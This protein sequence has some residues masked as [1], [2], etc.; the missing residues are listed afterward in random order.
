MGWKSAIGGI[1]PGVLQGVQAARGIQDIWNDQEERPIRQ[2]MLRTQEKATALDYGRKE[3]EER[4][5]NQPVNIMEHP[6]V[7]TM[8]KHATEDERKQITTRLSNVPQTQRGV[9]YLKNIFPLDEELVGIASKTG[10][11]KLNSDI[12]TKS[13][14]L[15]Q[16]QNVYMSLPPADPR[17]MELKTQLDTGYAEL[18]KIESILDEYTSNPTKPLNEVKINRIVIQYP[19]LFKDPKYKRALVYARETSDPEILKKIIT[20]RES[21]PNEWEVRV[22]AAGGDPLKA[23]QEKDRARKELKQTPS[24][25]SGSKTSKLVTITDGETVETLDLNIP[26]QKDEYVE[27]TQNGYYKKPAETQKS[28]EEKREEVKAQM[29][30]GIRLFR[31]TIKEEHKKVLV[32]AANAGDLTKYNQIMAGYKLPQIGNKKV[33]APVSK[34]VKSGRFTVEAE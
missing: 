21:M 7:Q 32:A 4:F 20:E 11:R 30:N 19:E 9:M 31:D 34:A 12:A 2:K 1:G 25:N 24:G 14:Q 18:K 15:N 6:A 29:K 17:K 3:E 10:A 5:L 33:A 23:I 22:A 13:S 8:M 27:L 26:E 16:L 28:L